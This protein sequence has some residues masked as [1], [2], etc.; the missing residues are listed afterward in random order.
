MIDGQFRFYDDLTDEIWNK[1]KIEF[2]PDQ[3]PKNENVVFENICDLIKND[4]S[5]KTVLLEK[6]YY[7]DDFID[8]YSNYFSKTFPSIFPHFC[9]RLHFF[10]RELTEDPTDVITFLEACQPDEYIGYISIRPLDSHVV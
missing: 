8:I 4:Y 1:I 5:C 6:Q 2:G 3:K 7:E 10:S 9:Q